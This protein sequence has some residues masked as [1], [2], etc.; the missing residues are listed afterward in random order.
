MVTRFLAMVEAPLRAA[1][2]IWFGIMAGFFWTFSNTVVPGLEI[3]P[4]TSGFVAMQKINEAVRNPGF[5]IF[6]FGACLLAA[7][8]L[9][10]GLARLRHWT[11]LVQVAAAAVYLG[12]VLFVTANKNVPL[13]R[14]LAEVRFTSVDTANPMPDYF[15]DW[16]YWNDIRFMSALLAFISILLIFRSRRNKT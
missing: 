4:G 2:S 16:L 6:F 10:Q 5:G 14:S 9:V 12:G 1:G 15:G 8:L 11:S 3:S 7:L 13:N